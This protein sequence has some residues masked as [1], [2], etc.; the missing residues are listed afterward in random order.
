MN[1]IVLR[2]ATMLESTVSATGSWFT[3]DYRY[4][5]DQTRTIAGT[6]NAS[7][8]MVLEGTLDDPT[9]TVSTIVTIESTTG[10]ASF[11]YMEP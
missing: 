2:R 6:M 11:A 1:N 3:C 5:S 7:D 8:V 9:V 4:S 10:A